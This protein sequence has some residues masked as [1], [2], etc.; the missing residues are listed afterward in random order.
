MDTF[1]KDTVSPYKF[2]AS[3]FLKQNHYIRI[4][5]NHDYDLHDDAFGNILRDAFY[6]GLVLYDVALINSKSAGSQYQ[7]EYIITHGHQLDESCH[8]LFA[9]KAGEIF[10]ECLSWAYEGADR[11][12]RWN[13]ETMGWARGTSWLNNTL[14]TGIPEQSDISVWL[15]GFSAWTKLNNGQLSCSDTKKVI[16]KEKDVRGF[17]EEA[18][19]HQIAWEYLNGT[20]DYDKVCRVLSKLEFF[21]YRHMKEEYIRT[22]WIKNFGAE[23]IRPK[24]VLGHSHEV[25]FNPVHQN[26]GANELF[27]WYFNTGSAGRFENLIW[28]LEIENNVPT[29]VSWSF[30]E[31]PNGTVPERRRYTPSGVSTGNLL[32]G[33]IEMDF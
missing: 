31:G 29:L 12:W 2:I 22:K 20:G 6:P 32:R 25:R 14:V 8:P 28:G 5:G 26:G 33:I 27:N 11:V 30:K 4:T 7:A 9:D 17:F 16:S 21:K 24:L 3:S 19:G 10:S 13:D 1:T 23:V 18:Q 15:N